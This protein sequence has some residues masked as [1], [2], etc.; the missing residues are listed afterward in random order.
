MTPAV[1]SPAIEALAAEVVEVFDRFRAPPAPAELARR[2]QTPLTPSE[3]RNLVRWGY[4]HVM[5]DFRFHLTLTG[6]VATERQPEV[7]GSLKR[8]FAGFIDRPLPIDG[9]ALF[10]QPVAGE[11]FHVHARYDFSGAPA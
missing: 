1:A 3:D 4:P 9:L 2:R 7:A 5:E 11:D 8:R 6:P 10:V